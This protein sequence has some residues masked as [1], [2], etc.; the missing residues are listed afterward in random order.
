MPRN[1]ITTRVPGRW[2]RDRDMDR[3]MDPAIVRRRPITADIMR[4]LMRTVILIHTLTSMARHSI[5]GLADAGVTD[6]A[7][8]KIELRCQIGPRGNHP[9]GL[10]FL[11]GDDHFASEIPSTQGRFAQLVI[12]VVRLL[13]A[14]AFLHRHR[15]ARVSASQWPVE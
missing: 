13:P 10:L 3:L 15:V 11:R 7:G 6:A 8:K 1:R 12:S 4:R 9:R 14:D 2:D 5:L